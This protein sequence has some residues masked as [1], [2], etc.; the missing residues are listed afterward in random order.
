MAK[1]DVAAALVAQGVEPEASTPAEFKAR[2]NAELTRWE[3]DVKSMKLDR[4]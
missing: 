2:V 4:D 1:P 3:K